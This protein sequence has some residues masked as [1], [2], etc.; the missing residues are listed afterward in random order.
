VSKQLTASSAPTI[1]SATGWQTNRATW[2]IALL[3]GVVALVPRLAELRA[4]VT[5]DEAAHWID[6][7]LRFSDAVADGRW[8]AAHQTGHPGVTLMWL[9]S[10]GLMLGRWAQAQG[11]AELATPLALL[12]WMRLPVALLQAL[13]LPLGYVLLRRLFAPR[14][15]LLAALLWATAPW[16]V[17][18]GRL[19]HLD[20]LL[21]SF[22][23]LSLLALLVSTTR[24][25]RNASFFLSPVSFFLCLSGILGGLAVL[26]KA[27]ALMLLPFVGLVL[28]AHTRGAWRARLRDAAAAFALWLGVAALTVLL[29]H[30]ALWADPGRVLHSYR[31]EIVD[32]GGRP[33]GAGQ[34]FLGQAIDDP[35]PL[36]Y[37]VA[38]ALRAT[39]L[40]LLGLLLFAGL[41]IADTRLHIKRWR[42]AQSKLFEA[43]INT[44][45]WLLAFVLFWFAVMTLG[46][47][48][49]DRY[50]LPAWPAIE[51]LA[52]IGLMRGFQ[53]CAAVWHMFAR[54]A[55]TTSNQ[56][57]ATGPKLVIGLALV[58]QLATLWY[59]H[60]YYLSY[61]NPLLG[62]GPVA[63][64][65]LL[66]G[67]GEGMDA[68]GAYLATRPDVNYGPVLSALVPTLQPYVAVPV[69]S[70][71]E[72]DRGSQNYAVVYLESVQRGANRDVYDAIRRTLPLHTVRIHGIDYATIYQLPRPFATPLAAQFGGALHLW[73]VTIAQEQQRVVVTP[74]WDVRAVPPADY[75]AFVHL[76]DGQG[77]L[78]AQV[79]AP[80]GGADLPP[81][82]VWQPGQQIA[83]PL[84]LP[85][86]AL[87]PGTYQLTQR[88]GADALL[89]G[90]IRVP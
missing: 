41:Q 50:V 46:P 55:T 7:T 21:A 66:I 18:H 45:L 83:V 85:V 86:P 4:F 24:I 9:G 13:L 32:N 29:L 90:T 48:K 81:T 65:A 2:A 77:N 79:D 26:T 38:S 19:L 62:G 47:K 89:L 88:V 64:R 51:I 31:E 6:R 59:Y 3:V 34:F 44:T 12:F 28:L 17:A 27:P 78:V 37:L 68:V 35:G 40:T 76:L 53:L 22:V 74:A 43:P 23:T 84:P 36:F 57:P 61:Y 60:P 16:L 72:L 87:P 63:Q 80:P 70:V 20:G 49:F 5:V 82:S 25:E 67:W 15:A 42:N 75:V 39:P 11:W 58:A 10:L 1:R 69:K 14:V 33:N 71:T 73:G 8:A 56:Q 30:P 52:A 54:R